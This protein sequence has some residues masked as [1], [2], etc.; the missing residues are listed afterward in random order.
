MYCLIA[1]WT[2]EERKKE[3]T[4]RQGETSH[5]FF[6]PFFF[7]KIKIKVRLPGCEWS[8]EIYLNLVD[9]EKEE[10][11]PFKIFDKTNDNSNLYL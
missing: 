6:L 8:R 3:T 2:D 5:F 10:R 9:L 1:A 7:D 4:V 11:I